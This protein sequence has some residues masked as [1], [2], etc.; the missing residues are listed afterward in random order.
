[1]GE[2]FRIQVPE[3]ID[4]KVSDWNLPATFIERMWQRLKND[5]GENPGG[6]LRTVNTPWGQRLNLY[7]FTLQ[8]SGEPPITYTF[9]FHFK[10]SEDETSLI[11]V[12]CGYQFRSG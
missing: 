3:R 11:V 12:E 1:M 2:P 9:M 8:D 4:A 10:Y 7:T 5:L 6:K